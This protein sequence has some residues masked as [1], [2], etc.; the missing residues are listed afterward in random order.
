[1]PIFNIIIRKIDR[2]QWFAICLL[3]IGIMLAN[4]TSIQPKKEDDTLVNRNTI[5]GV[6]LV[7]LSTCTSDLPV[8][9]SKKYF[10]IHN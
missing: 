10:I 1:M 3:V 2:R 5:L 4:Y 7:L 6:S 9:G 8:F